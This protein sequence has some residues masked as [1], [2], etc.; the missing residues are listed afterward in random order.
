MGMVELIIAHRLLDLP[1]L[2]CNLDH[3]WPIFSFYF[4][5]SQSK[6]SKRQQ[7]LLYLVFVVAFLFKT[8]GIQN[9]FE[10]IIV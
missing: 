2:F 9:M 5:T 6:I 7:M 10:W 3:I 8:L 1:E 4:C